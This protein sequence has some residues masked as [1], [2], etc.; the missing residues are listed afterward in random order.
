MFGFVYCFNKTL[1]NRSSFFIF[2]G[3]NLS[4]CGEN[5]YENESKSAAQIWLD[6]HG[7]TNFDMTNF[8]Y[9]SCTC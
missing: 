3:F 6:Y 1:K 7:T 2:H 9:Y 5:I 8:F 4:G